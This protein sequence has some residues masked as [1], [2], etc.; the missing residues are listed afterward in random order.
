MQWILFTII[1]VCCALVL[2]QD[3]KLRL[4]IWPLF[5][6]IAVS[7]LLFSISKTTSI[8]VIKNS[9]INLLF[10]LAQ[11]ATLKIIYR[12][13]EKDPVSRKIIDNKIGWG[14][15]LILLSCIF[16]FSPINFIIFYCSGLVFVILLHGISMSVK[17]KMQQH[18]GTI[19]MAGYLSL[20]LII[21]IFLS[22]IF[23]MNITSDPTIT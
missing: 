22:I 8:T 11:F 9:F 16:Y 19:P 2:Y 7:G 21:Y 5:P 3:V 18:S 14:D 17:S 13:K 10:L 1:A 6:I 12:I 4:V 15:I 23:N 20:F